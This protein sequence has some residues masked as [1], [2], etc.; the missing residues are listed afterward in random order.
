MI[1]PISVNSSGMQ[2]LYTQVPTTQ[3]RLSASTPEETKAKLNFAPIGPG[4]QAI[5]ELID[6]EFNIK[7]K[8][9]RDARFKK[10]ELLV[11]HNQL[12]QLPDSDVSLI[13]EIVKNTGIGL[14][15][16]LIE[17]K[18][19]K[20]KVV[21]GAYE[22]E[23]RRIYIFKNMDDDSLRKTLSHEVGHAVHN[24]RMTVYDF[25]VFLQSTKWKMFRQEQSFITGN[26]LY[27]IGVSL[28]EV[29]QKEW[30]N[31]HQHF[32]F[33][34]IKRKTSKAGGYILRAPEKWQDHPAF[35][36]PF[37]T[38]AFYYEQIYAH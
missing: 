19:T 11:I 12:K 36:N 15:L 32:D 28:V 5:A 17:A 35:S 27:N 2:R 13:E 6:K 25:L 31:L 30:S 34:T 23:N 4:E 16:E 33:E 22:K 18:M 37:E 29:A 8:N 7:I 26:S 24:H 20:N 38:F 14:E 3:A 10:N 9:T 1:S 21:L